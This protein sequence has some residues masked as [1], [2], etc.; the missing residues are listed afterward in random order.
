MSLGLIITL[1]VNQTTTKMPFQTHQAKQLTCPWSCTTPLFKFN[2]KR[3]EKKRFL[4]LFLSY[5]PTTQQ[6]MV[7]QGHL[8][9]DL[10]LM[11]CNSAPFADR[12]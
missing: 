9:L 5:L 10:T 1:V 12:W 4:T 8:L 7:K 11:W 6:D 3:K 2:L